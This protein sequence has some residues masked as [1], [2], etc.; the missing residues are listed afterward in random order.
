[1]L[2]IS[3]IE[4]NIFIFIINLIIIHVLYFLIQYPFLKVNQTLG[5]GFFRLYIISTDNKVVITPT[6]IIQREILFKVM[7]CFL[8]SINVFFGKEAL[9]DKCCFTKVVSK[10]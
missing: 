10:Y 4:M 1:M 8:L 2:L 6:Y 7:P 9:H 5:K 3:N